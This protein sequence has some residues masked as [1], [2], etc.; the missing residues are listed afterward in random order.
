MGYPLYFE[1][2]TVTFN[3]GRCRQ[4]WTKNLCPPI[5]PQVSLWSRFGHVALYDDTAVKNRYRIPIGV[6]AVIDN[7][8]RTRVVGQPITADTMTNTFVWLLGCALDSRGGRQPEIFI[9]DAD[10]AMAGQSDRSSRRCWRGVACGTSYP[11]IIKTL[12]KDLGG[13]MNV[14]IGA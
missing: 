11:N 9:Q 10:A 7:D 2:C 6:L 12:S 5:H 8:Y 13:R 3:P 14:N 1:Q 4:R